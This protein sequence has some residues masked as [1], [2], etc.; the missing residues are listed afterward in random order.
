M[1]LTPA[2]RTR[3]GLSPARRNSRPATSRYRYRSAYGATFTYF[4][5]CALPLFFFASAIA[6]DFTRT[7]VTNRTMGNVAAAAAAAGAWQLEDNSRIEGTND[8]AVAI[9]PGRGIRAARQTMCE[10]MVTVKSVVPASGS[11]R[12]ACLNGSTAPVDVYLDNYREWVM[13][14]PGGYQTIQVTSSYEVTG[15]IFL[16]YFGAGKSIRQT[17]TREASV[18][19][20]GDAN[21]P[22]NG[23][24]SRPAPG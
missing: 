4:L 1:S 2:R 18:C 23:Y 10:G 15:M 13:G 14:Y 22:T 7:L 19:L 8:N 9:D 20:P 21:G 11:G 24:C 16:Q 12:I 6:V 3:R 17:V 5:M